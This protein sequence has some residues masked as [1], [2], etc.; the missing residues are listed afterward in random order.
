MILAALVAAATLSWAAPALAQS[1]TDTDTDPEPTGV[2][3]LDDGEDAQPESGIVRDDDTSETV[4]RIRRDLLIIA[5]VTA[6]GLVV[7]VWHT[8]PARRVRVAAKRAGVVLDGDDP[9][10]T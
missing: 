6:A 1:D 10:G 7:Y 2:T 4:A 8:S 3:V 9:H 5:G